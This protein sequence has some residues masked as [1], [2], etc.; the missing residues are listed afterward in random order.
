[1]SAGP[2]SP[3]RRGQAHGLDAAGLRPGASPLPEKRGASCVP[4]TSR[5]VPVPGAGTPGAPPSS[6]TKGTASGFMTLLPGSRATVSGSSHDTRA[7]TRDGK[8]RP[9]A[10]P[11]TAWAPRPPRPPR[12][13]RDPADCAAR[14]SYREELTPRRVDARGLGMVLRDDGVTTR[15]SWMNGHPGCLAFSW[16]KQVSPGLMHG[17]SPSLG[18]I[19]CG[20][21]GSRASRELST[22]GGFEGPM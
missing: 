12:P 20:H 7:E 21:D 5:V 19:C 13:P 2:A 14:I 17:A 6:R 15:R 22:L 3:G 1:M 4:I 18:A 9:L 8:T 10:F 11:V 16:V